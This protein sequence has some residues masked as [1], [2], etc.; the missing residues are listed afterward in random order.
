MAHFFRRPKSNLKQITSTTRPLNKRK[1]KMLE[2][3][4]VANKLSKKYVK[5]FG[6]LLKIQLKTE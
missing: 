5:Y 4:K 3:R 2:T 6:D 1:Q